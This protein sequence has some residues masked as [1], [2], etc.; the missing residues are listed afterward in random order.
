MIYQK[1]ILYVLTYTLLGILRIG[2][3]LLFS[4]DGFI[5]EQDVPEHK[6]TIIGSCTRSVR[7]DRSH[8]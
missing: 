1:E 5:Q 7:Y 2:D 4:Y 8:I 3:T 6:T